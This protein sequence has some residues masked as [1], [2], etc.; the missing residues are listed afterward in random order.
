MKSDRKDMADLLDMKYFKRTVKIL[1]DELD[2]LRMKV[3]ALERESN[4]K[5]V[6]NTIIVGVI[7]SICQ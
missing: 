5:Q 1:E 4:W 2:T 7:S 3:K 6:Y